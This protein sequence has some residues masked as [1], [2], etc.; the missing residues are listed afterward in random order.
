MSKRQFMSVVNCE[1]LN[2]HSL[3][4]KHCTYCIK[5]TS[6]PTFCNRY[7]ISVDVYLYPQSISHQR[8]LRTSLIFNS[9][10]IDIV[11]NLLQQLVKRQDQEA[12]D[13]IY[14]P[15]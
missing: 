13:K 9:Y 5:E 8:S 4:I 12:L 11:F 7:R 15:N 1:H 2:A 3:Y 10:L 14:G 6:L